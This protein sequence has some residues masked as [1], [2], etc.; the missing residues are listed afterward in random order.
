MVFRTFARMR[1]IGRKRVWYARLLLCV[2]LP[3]LIMSSVHIHQPSANSSVEC[4]ACLHHI[5]HDGHL[6][7]ASYSIDNCL[8]CHFLSLPYVAAAMVAV[9]FAVTSFGRVRMLSVN[10]IVA[11]SHYAKRLR[12]PPFRL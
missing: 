9:L 1:E 8:L 3:V 6:T 12:A 4:Y 10:D 11:V 2:F 5:H 7:S